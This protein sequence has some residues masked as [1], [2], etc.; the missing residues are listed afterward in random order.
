MT[1]WI[2]LYV[3]VKEAEKKT[4]SWDGVRVLLGG[5][6]AGLFDMTRAGVPG[7]PGFT[8]TTQAC[9][10]YR[11]TGKFPAGMWVQELAALKVVE[12]RT[13]KKFGDPTN[14][15][16]VSVPDGAEFSMPGMMN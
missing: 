11:K 6:G 15:L 1:K 8:V 16:L 10:E 14:P 4:G 12:K 5:K 13:G 7:P 9:N 3:E 2:Y